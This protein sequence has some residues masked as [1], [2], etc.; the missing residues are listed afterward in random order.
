MKIL[1]WGLIPYH[2]AWDRQKKLFTDLVE[3]KD[4][5][6]FLIL[7]EHLPVYTVGFR[8]DENNLLIDRKELAQRNI[9]FIRIE[10]GGDVTYH[11]PGQLVVYPIINLIRHGI[12]VKQYVH[13][14][15]KSVL[16]LL[17]DF[18]IE[19]DTSEDAI[20]VWLDWG[21]PEARKICAIGVKIRNGVTMH[22]LALN[23]NTDL[24]AFKLINPCGFT[25]KD[26]TSISKEIGHD[27][28]MAFIKDRLAEIISDNLSS[29]KEA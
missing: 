2:E 16:K 23:V 17:R 19:G 29:V 24:L 7:L 10:R 11:G 20:G 8:G 15:E 1:D 13:L 21:T 9:D 27:V 26:V 5:E 22:G 6:E 28:D 12:G 3:N 14:L 25:D 4:G 18:G